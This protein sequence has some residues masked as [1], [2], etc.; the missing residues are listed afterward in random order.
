MGAFVKVVFSLIGL[1]FLVGLLAGGKDA[2][3]VVSLANTVHGTS[4]KV[5]LAAFN[6][7]RDGSSYRVA[8]SVLGCEGAQTSRSTLGGYTTVLYSW[9][10]AGRPRSQHERAVRPQIARLA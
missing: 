7:L 1:L 8:V 6:Q 2:P 3:G 10:G 9:D 5:S 4:C